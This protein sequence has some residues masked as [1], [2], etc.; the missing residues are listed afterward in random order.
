[1]NDTK[2]IVWSKDDCIFCV[3]AKRFLTSKTIH[4]EERNISS[5]EWTR[6][7]LLEAVPNAKTLPQIFLYGEYIGGYDDLLK[8]AEDHG[9][10]SNF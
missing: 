4:F 10:Y 2:T 5:D 7:Q 9:M 3:K 6:E 8:Y 1:M